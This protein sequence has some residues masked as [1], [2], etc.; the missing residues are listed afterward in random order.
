MTLKTNLQSTSAFHVSV[1]QLEFKD[2]NAMNAKNSHT[3][4]VPLIID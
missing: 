4:K 1:L 2:G 3:R